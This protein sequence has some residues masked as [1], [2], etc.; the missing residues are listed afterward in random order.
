MSLSNLETLIKVSEIDTPSQILDSMGQKVVKR[1]IKDKGDGTS[2]PI[3]DLSG[4]E[5]TIRE[6]I[7]ATKKLAKKKEMKNVT[8]LYEILMKDTSTMSKEQYKKHKITCNYI[9]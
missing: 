3:V 1:K 2:S 7:V 6:E 9:L 4:M 5:A 8:L